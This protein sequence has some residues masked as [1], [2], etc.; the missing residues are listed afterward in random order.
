MPYALYA[1]AGGLAEGA[2]AGVCRRGRA[3]VCGLAE[4]A[5]AGV[6]RR[7]VCTPAYAGV[8]RRG[9]ADR[10]M[11]AP[12]YAPTMPAYAGASGLAEGAY[13]GVCRRLHMQAPAYALTTPAYAPTTPAYAGASGLAE[14]AELAEQT[15]LQNRRELL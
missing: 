1:G 14:L 12:A 7:C 10:R 4:G 9:R 13:A 3:C 15:F 2:Y 11:Q 6:C 5:Y 8:C